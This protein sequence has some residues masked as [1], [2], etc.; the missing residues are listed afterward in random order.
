MPNRIGIIGA[1]YE[2]FRPLVSDLSTRELMFEAAAKAYEDASID[3]RRD[4]GSFICCTEDLWEGWS[5]ADEMVPDQIGAAGRPLCTVPADAITGLGNA[6]MHILS[7]VADVVVLEAHSKAADVL[8]KE[9]V[10]NLAL[11]PVMIRP[12]GA[13][14]DVLAALE[15]DGFLRNSDYTLGDI[16]EVLVSS[17]KK[18]LR[19]PRASYGANISAEDFEDAEVVSSPLRRLDKAAFAEAGIVLVLASEAWTRRNA[20]DAVYVDG[21]AWSSSLPWFD[22]GEFASVGYARDSYM[23]ALERAGAKKGLDAFDI[24]ELD[25]TY[26][27]KA[28]QHLHSLAGSSAEEQRVMSGSGPALNP[29]GGSLGAGNLLEA[30]AMHRLLECYLQLKGEAGPGQVRGA[31]RALVQSWRGVPTAT[32]GV[33]LLSR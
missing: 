14:S 9:A 6:A 18:A 24:I 7:G 11:E 5:I 21:F 20:R 1:G 32:G 31:E 13:G 28:L 26:S 23:R 17:K 33:A 15:M 27:Y 4:V 29:S 3:P 19:N 2:G 25:D 16:D 8:D 30:S 22:G 12:L 10:E